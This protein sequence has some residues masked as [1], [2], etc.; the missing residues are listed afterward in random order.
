M[1]DLLELKSWLTIPEACKYL[2]NHEIQAAEADILDL[3]LEQKLKLSV[4]FLEDIW[5]EHQKTKQSK[6]VLGEFDLSMNGNEWQDVERE[7]ERI[8]GAKAHILHPGHASNIGYVELER[9]GERYTLLCDVNNIE[10]VPNKQITLMDA[11]GLYGKWQYGVRKAELDRFILAQKKTELAENTEEI[12]KLN[13][14]IIELK[15]ENERLKKL[16]E[17]PK[18]KNSNT[19][20]TL[21]AFFMLEREG[22]NLKGANLNSDDFSLSGIDEIER[23]ILHLHKIGTLSYTVKVGAI[24]PTLRK[25]CKSKINMINFRKNLSSGSQ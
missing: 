24:S 4:D 12:E 17:E 1:K 22:V 3:A 19:V 16:L 11:P 6:R 21:L 15:K 5:V 13:A 10:H 9:N 2:A 7:R 20:N 8:G 23:R 14:K 18:G 25:A